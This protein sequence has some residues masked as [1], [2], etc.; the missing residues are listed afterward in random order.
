MVVMIAAIAVFGLVVADAFSTPSCRAAT[1]LKTAGLLQEADKRYL[2][3]L[4]DDAESSCAANGHESVAQSLC[5][6]AKELLAENLFAESRKIYTAVNESEPEPQTRCAIQGL[7]NVSDAEKKEKK[8]EDDEKESEDGE[9]PEGGEKT[10]ERIIVRVCGCPRLSCES[11][12]CQRPT[13]R[14]TDSP[15][16]HRKR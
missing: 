6:R 13:C 4:R 5:S 7:V 1:A 2:D 12:N 15:N 8:R 14:H 9:T 11:A 16:K 10:P 3:V